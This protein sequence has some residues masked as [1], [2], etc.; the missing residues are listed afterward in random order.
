MKISRRIVASDSVDGEVPGA[1]LGE[2]LQM[3][4]GRFEE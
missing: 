3:R 2:R 4:F 1:G